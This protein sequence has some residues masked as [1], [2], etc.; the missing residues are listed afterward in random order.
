MKRDPLIGRV[1]DDRF[2]IRSLIG[3][4]SVGRVYLAEH[5][6]LGRPSAIKVLKQQF[7]DD[8]NIIGR[9]RREARA[10][11]RL[12]HQ[13]IV[14]VEA[15]GSTDDQLFFLVLEYV[16]GPS[17][18][19]LIKDSEGF[20]PL[21]RALEILRQLS[22][23]VAYAHHQGVIH[24][25]LKPDNVLLIPR[26]GRHS[27]D[28]VKILDFGLAKILESEESLEL[29]S[30]GDVFGTPAYMAPEQCMGAPTD[31]R[32]D[33]YGIGILAYELV[34]GR[35]PFE[36]TK[37]IELLLKHTQE[38]PADPAVHRTDRSLPTEVSDVIL[39]CLEKRPAD[40]YQTAD[41][42]RDVFAQLLEL[43]RGAARAGTVAREGEFEITDVEEDARGKV[44]T[45]LVEP[46]AVARGATVLWPE[47]QSD[48][49][50]R[51]E[52]WIFD[53]YCKVTRLIAERLR[54]TGVTDAELGRLLDEAS[55]IEDEM[56]REETDLAFLEAEADELQQ[57]YLE[58]L[59]YLNNQ[60]VDLSDEKASWMLRANPD[61]GRI[62]E[63]D[64]EVAELE[65]LRVVVESERRGETEGIEA[66]IDQRVLAMPQRQ[67]NLAEK[68]LALA[69]VVG[70]LRPAEADEKLAGFYAAFDR[71][72][73]LLDE[74]RQQVG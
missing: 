22:D 51:G 28:I 14:R 62:A 12:V 69:E 1:I 21:E 20:V 10:T 36:A 7:T 53:R 60:L 71:F 32:S 65:A 24:R 64:R 46:D 30:E 74:V 42:L 9:F 29:T 56:L 52:P 31:E 57:R 73:S 25:D 18:R 34:A 55:A 72:Q 66:D 43:E 58:R 6:H 48:F 5:L 44:A 15:F 40:R 49:A 61:E 54:T 70:R 3:S 16:E 68:H 59:A 50:R 23:A 11:S 13:G 39:R 41:E 4:G 63:I 8:S 67:E 26:K 27:R 47:S 37:A 35:R 38:I 2:R 19:S 33:I 17:L 45:L